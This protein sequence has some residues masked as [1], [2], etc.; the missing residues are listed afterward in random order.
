MSDAPVVFKRSKAKQSQRA[1]QTSPGAVGDAEDSQNVE[2]P[3]TLVAKLKKRAK[4]KARLS[5]G[6][7]DEEGEGDVFQVKKSNL[8]QK[9]ALGKNAA[10]SSLRN[11][12]P[13]NLEQASITPRSQSGPV[14]DQA[15][16]SALKAS[17][18][19]S[20]RPLPTSD[21]YDADISMDVGDS[22]IQTIQT[23]DIF[24]SETA[25]PS[26]SSIRVA[27][28]K[29][30]RLRNTTGEDFISLT[31]TCRSEDQGPHPESRLVR[32][33][34]ELGE[35]DDEYAEYTSAQER[36]A[37]GKKSRKVEASKRRDAM[38]DMIADAE[39]EDEETKEWEQEQIRR[40]G[41]RSSAKASAPAKQSYKPAPIPTLSPVPTIGPALA[42]LANSL[43]QLTLS[44]AS[45][46][47]AL[48]TLAKERLAVDT[49]EQELRELVD[50]AE[51]KR[52]W[53]GAFQEWVEGV[54]GFLD[55]KFPQ[56]EKL[57]EDYESLLKQRFNRVADRRR[58]DDEDDLSTVLGASVSVQENQPLDEF[59]RS[60]APVVARRE[61]RADRL[62]R[63]AHRKPS[64]EEEGYSTDS[65]MAPA[66][67]TSYQSVLAELAERQT[68]VLA[69]VRAAE[70]KDP[71]KSKWWGEWREKY[72]DSY[73]GAWGGL[74]LVGAWEF[75]VRLEI[76]GWDAI[77]DPRPLDGFKWYKNLYAYSRPGSDE[78]G[79]GE[80]G[81]DGDLVSAMISTAI[82]P[83]LCKLIE[84]GALDVYSSRHTRRVI[85]LAEEVEASVENG[86][87]KFQMLI[88]AVTNAF[89][90]AVVDTEAVTVK[91]QSL[92]PA[93]ASFDPEAIPAR[94]RILARRTKLLRN[95]VR[96]RKYSGERFGIGQLAARLVES[97]MKE[98]AVGGWDVGGQDALRKAAKI[99]PDEILPV[100][101]KH[102]LS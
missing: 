74:G 70:F 3:S 63:R 54:A 88:R 81:P 16:L 30:E 11:T 4:P 102:M 57:E 55:E 85:D 17:T 42:R 22:S 19:S 95:M 51:L 98:L 15:Y 45:N 38:K 14:Y 13:A 6:G 96:W 31:V 93:P 46:T 60:V 92:P 89:E 41:H 34:D 8:S 90:R 87:Q 35:G 47:T 61:R 100:G 26:E 1:R 64:A 10:S 39:E 12:L 101:L 48:G 53:F 7:D 32:E 80:L 65:S 83:R 79:E 84:A 27:K 68:A 25:I 67:Q 50:K 28:E 49:R 33:E 82:I 40:A 97:S 43:A 99:V 37:L 20:R 71:A 66:E 52:G 78:N 2:S 58:T 18:P 29:R 21:S 56:L 91:I 86:S 94:S 75:W 44:H 59:G 76:V 36:I 73:V 69:D 23:V 5:F 9:L 24:E 62:A 77:E 72:A